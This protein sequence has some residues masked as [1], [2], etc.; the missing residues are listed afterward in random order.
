MR[1]VIVSKYGGSSIT[2]EQDIEQIKRITEDD[3]R[4]RVIVVS[5][6]G[7]RNEKDKKVT[8]LLI[9]LAE[10]KD[11][12]LISPIIERYTLLAP[13][14]EMHDLEEILLHR[15]DQCLPKEAYDDALK[16]FGEEAC[17]KIVA[18]KIKATYLDPKELFLVTSH[19]GDAKILPKSVQ[20]IGG[21]IW[22][23]L[24][25]VPGF[26]GYTKDGLIATFSRGGSDLTGAYLA[27]SLDAVV[28]ENFTD[29]EGILAADPALVKNPRKINVLTYTEIRDL[30]YSGFTVF[31]QE[32]MQPVEEKRI[33]V[34]VRKTAQYPQE[35][36]YIVYERESN[37]RQPL[38]GVAYQAGFCAFTIERFGLNE[39]QGV[40]RDLLDLFEKEKKP[41][42]F[43]FNTIDDI[44]IISRTSAFQSYLALTNVM[45]H[46]ESVTGKK[47]AACEE[48]LGCL[49]VAG[50]GLK[51]RRG[52]AADIQQTLARAGVNIKFISQGS[53]ERCIV[54]GI[55]SEDGKKA[56]NAVY[57]RYLA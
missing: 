53:Q 33:P 2:T 52:I 12:N 44:T 10:K 26:Y 46:I 40:M 36:T 30:A 27:A 15:V 37:L 29:R 17:A 19:F 39:Q 3:L 16:A 47:T 22:D 18:E 4:R 1:D 57:K 38:V 13:G 31:H 24:Y 9:E 5:A 54:Y 28:Y 23:G 32:A 50:K 6:P 51:G 35:G 34:H 56:V 41:V 43:I 7:K 14:R 21:T 48:H 25:V 42:E 49:V 20:M 45:K 55:K 11:H 8:D